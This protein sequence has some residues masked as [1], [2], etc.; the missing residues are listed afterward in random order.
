MP[1]IIFGVFGGGCQR[2]F[3][4]AVA[5]VLVVALADVFFTFVGVL[6][7]VICCLLALYF[8]VIFNIIVI[9]AR[10]RSLLHGTEHRGV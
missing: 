10:G 1:L 6:V 8:N 7:C 3:N 4:N 9:V 2:L 5:T